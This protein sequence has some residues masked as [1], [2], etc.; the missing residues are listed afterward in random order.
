LFELFDDP[1][2]GEQFERRVRYFSSSLER[3]IWLPTAE[4]I[5]VQKLRWGRSKD[6]DDARD[7]LAVQGTATLDMDH[8]RNWCAVQATTGRL[9]NIIAN[10]PPI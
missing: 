8:V 2:V 5:V 3:D 4:D 7:V 9:E 6:L 1:F 10:L